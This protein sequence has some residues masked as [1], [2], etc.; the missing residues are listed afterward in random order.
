MPICD[1][2]REVYIKKS[3]ECQRCYMRRYY[4]EKPEKFKRSPGQIEQKRERDKRKRDAQRDARRDTRPLGVVLLEKTTE[5]FAA[6]ECALQ[7]RREW[8]ARNAE[9]RRAY[10][11]AYDDPSKG[12]RNRRAA[13]KREV[14]TVFRS[15]PSS[16]KP[17]TDE[18]K[19]A[20]RERMRRYIA[21]NREYINERNKV[22]QVA[23]RRAR[24]IEPKTAAPPCACGRPH[25]AKGMCKSCYMREYRTNKK[26]EATHG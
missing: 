1:C 17:L 22:R 20:K 3:N 7:K 23:Y 15:H 19:A 13:D 6:R 8:N 25:E 24:G 16:R 14:E 2:G 21:E 18:Q 12:D 5:A 10:R 4:R 9:A 11:K 26:K